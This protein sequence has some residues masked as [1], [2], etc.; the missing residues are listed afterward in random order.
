M[1]LVA[2]LLNPFQIFIFIPLLSTNLF[3]HLSV[4]YRGVNSIPFEMEHKSRKK[5]KKGAKI[6]GKLIFILPYEDDDE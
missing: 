2:K 6:Y 5:E 3:T 1:K 4:D